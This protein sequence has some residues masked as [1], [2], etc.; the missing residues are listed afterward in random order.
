MLHLKIVDSPIGPLTLATRSG[1]LCVLHFGDDRSV[2]DR[3]LVAGRTL[4]ENGDSALTRAVAG[5]AD[6]VLDT[7]LDTSLDPS[8]GGATVRR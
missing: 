4:L 2:V 8:R 6:G 7:S 1:R 5:L 3:A